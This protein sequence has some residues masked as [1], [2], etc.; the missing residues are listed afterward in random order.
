MARR[1]PTKR[2][3]HGSPGAGRRFFAA[4]AAL[5]AVMIGVPLLLV[6]CSQ[7]GLDAP[8]PF[9][10][11]GTTDE[12]RAFLERDLT[13]TE[14]A[15]IAMRGLLVAGWLFWLAMAVSVVASILEATGSGLRA[16][17]PKFTMFAGRGRWI[18][19]G[20]TTV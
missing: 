8:H 2:M 18:A 13:A 3:R 9:P 6:A 15:P 17:G 11:I 14:I 19:A 20:L 4:L 1:P 7:V 16:S 10:G 5:V 12:I